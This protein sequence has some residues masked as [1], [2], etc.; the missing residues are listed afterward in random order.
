MV[1]GKVKKLLEQNLEMNKLKV[2]YTAS[3]NPWFN[4]ATEDWIFAT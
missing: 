2:F 1:S 3:T 4:L